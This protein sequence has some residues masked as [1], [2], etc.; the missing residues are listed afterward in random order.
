[1]NSGCALLSGPAQRGEASSCARRSRRRPFVGVA[2]WVIRPA[3]SP[4]GPEPA[5]ATP[6]AWSGRA[7]QPAHA[8]VELHMHAPTA[9]GGDGREL[10]LAPDDHVSAAA[11]AARIRRRRARPSR[12]RARQPARPRAARAP[13][14]RRRRR[15]SWPLLRA[16]RARGHRAVPVAVGLDDGA[17]RRPP[18]QLAEHRAQLRSIAARFTLATARRARGD[19]RRGRRGERVSQRRSPPRAHARVLRARA[20]SASITSR[21][22]DPLGRADAPRASRPA[23]AWTQRRRSAAV[24]ASS[25]WA[26]APRSRR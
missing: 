22:H 7:S 2:K 21:G 12:A 26:A 15:A 4:R 17:Q 11:S 3:S 5:A 14:A 25:P 24:K 16:R 1:M 23:C 18:A 20:G 6:E 8:G 13:R 10:L 19:A 9:G